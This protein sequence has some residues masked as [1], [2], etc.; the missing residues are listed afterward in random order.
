[1]AHLLCLLLGHRRTPVA[2]ATNRFSCRRCGL[3]LDPDPEPDPLPELTT[4]AEATGWPT[5][6]S[7]M[8]TRSAR[9][10]STRAF[11]RSRPYAGPATRARE[12]HRPAR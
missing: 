3:A 11:P 7:R 5:A 9:A 6:T 12:R 1:M 2:F 4:V 8:P 10:A